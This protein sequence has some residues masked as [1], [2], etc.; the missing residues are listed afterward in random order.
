MRERLFNKESEGIVTNR[1]GITFRLERRVNDDDDD[2]DEEEEE[3]R[4][5][6]IVLMGKNKNY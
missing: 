3:R 1:I 5:K 4:M 2:D 6:E